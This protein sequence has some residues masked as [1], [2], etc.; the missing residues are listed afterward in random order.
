MQICGIIK[1]SLLLPCIFI[2]LFIPSKNLQFLLLLQIATSSKVSL[3]LF[4]ILRTKNKRQ[5]Q[6]RRGEN[7]Q[8]KGKKNQMKSGT[9]RI[10]FTVLGK[11]AFL[12]HSLQCQTLLVCLIHPLIYSTPQINSGLLSS[13][14]LTQNLL[15][16]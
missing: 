15:L 2:V 12:L 16:V 10:F 7:L 4:H 11:A 14:V 6:T 13:E 3:T 1:M 5:F 8:K 9:D